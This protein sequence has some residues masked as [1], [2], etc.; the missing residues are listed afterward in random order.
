[1]G[2]LVEQLTA[3]SR[4]PEA[5]RVL[6]N[7]V[8]E[9]V[10]AK[11]GIGGMALKTGFAAA[12]KIRPDLVPTAVDRLLPQFAEKLEPHWLARGDQPFG[13]YLVA[14]AGQVSDELLAV[15]DAKMRNP[16]LAAIAK[17]YATLRPKAKQQVSEAL[18]R[19]GA[20]IESLAD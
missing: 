1:M 11:S 5:V 2:S 17:V 15:T 10:K 4:R 18:P 20:A 9:E 19:L 12:T 8:E 13:D 14:H 16:N 3:E 6:S 7:V